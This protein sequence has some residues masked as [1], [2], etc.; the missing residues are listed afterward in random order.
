MHLFTVGGVGIERLL[1]FSGAIG[2]LNASRSLSLR[3]RQARWLEG[4]LATDSWLE[5]L[6]ANNPQERSSR[7]KA[8]SEAAIGAQASCSMH[9]G[10]AK[11]ESQ[12]MRD[13]MPFS[14]E[15]MLEDHR[16]PDACH[17]TG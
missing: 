7:R 2:D 12:P 6:K 10:V 8:V 17:Q 15:L 5:L 14:F 13:H 3:V 11:I 9:A 16:E 4:T 1:S